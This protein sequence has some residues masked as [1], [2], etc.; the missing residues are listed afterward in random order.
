M[1]SRLKLLRSQAGVTMLQVMVFLGVVVL[2]GSAIFEA[3][4]SSKSALDKA[5][6]TGEAGALTDLAIERLRALLVDSGATK[7]E[8]I[9]RLFN[10]PMRSVG[11]GNIYVRLPATRSEDPL[12]ADWARTF[13]SA[14]WAAMPSSAGGCTQDA[15]NRCFAP[16]PGMPGISDAFIARKPIVVATLV[17]VNMRNIGGR[18]VDPA[19]ISA[20]SATSINARDL[21]FVASAKVLVPDGGNLKMAGSGYATVWAGQLTCGFNAMTGQHFLLNPSAIGSGM[22]NDP[23]GPAGSGTIFSLTTLATPDSDQPIDVSYLQYENTHWVT[24]GNV[25]KSDYSSGTVSS[26]CR[27]EKYRCPKAPAGRQ[28]LATALAVEA[29]VKY[30]PNSKIVSQSVVAKP[31]I[32]FARSNGQGAIHGNANYQLNGQDISPA[33]PTAATYKPGFITILQSPNQVDARFTEGQNM[34]SQICVAPSYNKGSDPIRPQFSGVPSSQYAAVGPLGPVPDP[35]SGTYCSCCS[36]KQCSRSGLNSHMTCTDQLPEPLDSRVSECEGADPNYVYHH[37]IYDDLDGANFDADSCVTASG[38]GNNLTFASNSCSDSLPPLC[39]FQGKLATGTSLDTHAASPVTFASARQGCY[40]LG[41]EK[42]DQGELNKRMTMQ[43]TTAELTPLAPF[44]NG[45]TYRFV[46]VATA[47]QFLAPETDSQLSGAVA[48]IAASSSSTGKNWV[49]LRTDHSRRFFAPP[50]ELEGSFLSSVGYYTKPTKELVVFQD[51]AMPAAGN[52]LLI[53]HSR[54]FFGPVASA[55]AAAGAHVICRSLSATTYT[56]GTV[57]HPLFLTNTVVGDVSGAAEACAA[58]RGVFLP[59]LR[60]TEW[61]YATNLVAPPAAD[62]PW[63]DVAG[64]ANTAWI[65]FTK[66]SSGPG[67]RLASAPV[68]G[69]AKVTWNGKAA[70]GT[71]AF[72]LCVKRTGTKPAF[73]MIS[74]TGSPSPACSGA[75]PDPFGPFIDSAIVDASD[76][77]LF[78]SVAHDGGLVADADLVDLN[79]AP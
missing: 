17:A 15:F 23:N 27:E 68:E 25:F 61:H 77:L 64:V 48:A 13:P 62:Y 29:V 55:N 35:L 42:V 24:N 47:G 39:Y 9:C 53:V 52:N 67:Y 6:R 57:A 46:N 72:R 44:L 74:A 49:G 18:A 63:P 78:L 4:Q 76:A 28:W 11:T 5:K 37:T 79:N 31:E 7:Q 71:A 40:K 73:K 1:R 38:D 21:G 45:S 41:D 58:E 65:G 60:G 66:I 14:Q 2:V 10:T 54:K 43:N 19:P 51:T 56:D 20:T 33:D 12:I 59:P 34:C 3:T 22:V 8:G 32:F 50:P 36:D 26:A 30:V 70:T 69:T 16:Q 75:Y